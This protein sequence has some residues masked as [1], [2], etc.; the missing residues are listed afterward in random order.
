MKLL[1]TQTH[2]RLNR[3]QIGRVYIIIWIESFFYFDLL[4]FLFFNLCML[5]KATK[6]SS[7]QT[8]LTIFYKLGSNPKEQ[9]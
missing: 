3:S 1:K 9:Y 4:W 7:W 2:P 5:I 8:S 6:T